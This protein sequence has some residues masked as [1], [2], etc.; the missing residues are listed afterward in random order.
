MAQ[1]SFFPA[2]YDDELVYSWVARYHVGVG[3]ADA[4]ATRKRLFGTLTLSTTLPGHLGAFAAQLPASFA[5]D[6]LIDAHT[7]FPYFSPFLAGSRWSLTRARMQDDD[8]TA[9]KLGL[10]V[11]GS[12]V[13]D[14][15]YLRLCLDC[16]DEQ[17]KAGNEPHWLRSHQLPGARL[18][19][20]H[21]VALVEGCPRCGPF[22]HR[23]SAFVLPALRCTGCQ[24]PYATPGPPSP[25]QRFAAA[26]ARFASLSVELLDAALPMIPARDRIAAYDRASDELQLPKQH[27]HD[28]LDERIRESWDSDFLTYLGVSERG[29]RAVPRVLRESDATIHPALHLL[30]IS[31]LFKSVAQFAQSTRFEEV[32]A[33]A[34]QSDL[35]SVLRQH[36]FDVIKAAAVVSMDAW[37]FAK[38]VREEGIAFASQYAKVDPRR[39][40]LIAAGLRAG[41]PVDEIASVAGVRIE[42]VYRRLRSDT[43]AAAERERILRAAHLA[44]RSS[45]V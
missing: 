6:D 45:P 39:L 28:A 44:S 23:R 33:S 9:V 26:S 3:N 41:A 42:T 31:V 19:A 37:P 25:G 16:V 21:S 29:T 17:I 10:G 27:R 32:G 5:V 40:A 20:R 24:T 2:P 11:I 43:S 4:M 13:K 30:V 7:I 12:R 14:V 8:A 18:C 22:D 1:L 15:R 38:A 35:L 34:S 36:E